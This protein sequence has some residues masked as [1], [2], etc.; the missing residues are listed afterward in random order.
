MNMGI[1]II[2]VSDYVT[3]HFLSH[4]ATA[5]ARNACAD[6]SG[7]RFA[8]DRDPKQQKWADSAPNRR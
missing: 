4:A 8:P 2:N 7:C 5:Q 6:G 3:I 1:I